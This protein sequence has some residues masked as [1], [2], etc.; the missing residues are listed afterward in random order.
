[1]IRGMVEWI[2]PGFSSR[3]VQREREATE[4]S[5]H[6]PWNGGMDLAWLLL[7]VGPKRER[8]DRR[9]PT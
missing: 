5:R 7:K 8:G 4:G 9:E 1:M 6:D 2:S 3:L